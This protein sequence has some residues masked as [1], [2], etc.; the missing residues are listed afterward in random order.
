M[1][2]ASWGRRSGAPSLL[3][4]PPSTSFSSAF[5]PGPHPRAPASPSVPGLGWGLGDAEVGA[6]DV[7]PALVDLSRGPRSK[8]AACWCAVT[9]GWRGSG[10]RGEELG[11]PP[12]ALTAGQ[13]REHPAPGA[14]TLA[15]KG[16]VAQGLLG[17]WASPTRRG[18]SLPTSLPLPNAHPLSLYLKAP[19]PPPRC[20]GRCGSN[21]R[22]PGFL[23]QGAARGRCLSR[24]R[25][26]VSGQRP[27][28]LHHPCSPSL[29]AV[30]PG[31]EWAAER[32]WVH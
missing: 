6:V 19:A 5:N 12:P 32:H 2:A 16:D 7:A 17:S 31:P 9:L 26:C 3:A 11:P 25:F 20:G 15:V 13:S 22:S 30:S 28:S 10:A 1:S 4:P 24:G 18:P 23:S 8:P 21:R 29:S 14:L 27:P